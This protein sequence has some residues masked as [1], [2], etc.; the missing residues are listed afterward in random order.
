MAGEDEMIDVRRRI[1]LNRLIEGGAA[2]FA[3]IKINHHRDI[4]GKILR[5]PFV[6]K[7]LRDEVDS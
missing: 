4:E 7:S 6:R 5:S 2:I 1:S 3:E